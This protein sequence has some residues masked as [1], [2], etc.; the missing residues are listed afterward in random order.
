MTLSVAEY[1]RG[2][3]DE[4]IQRA[5]SQP[6]LHESGPIPSNLRTDTG[7]KDAN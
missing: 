5:V 3:T 2:E 1:K 4:F 6:E 7:L